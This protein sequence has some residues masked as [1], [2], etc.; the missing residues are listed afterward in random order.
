MRNSEGTQ[1]ISKELGTL[2][3]KNFFYSFSIKNKINRWDL[4]NLKKF[5][6][7]QNWDFITCFK[8]DYGNFVTFVSVFNTQTS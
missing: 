3:N 1:I 4:M 5:E 2:P 8:I 6:N 7:D